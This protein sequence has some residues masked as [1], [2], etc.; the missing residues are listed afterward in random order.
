MCTQC[1][2]NKK[3]KCCVAT[4]EERQAAAARCDH[5]IKRGFKACNGQ[6]PCDVCI[7]HNTIG[8]CRPTVEANLGQSEDS[9]SQ[10]T[11]VIQPAGQ[12]TASGSA[13]STTKANTSRTQQKP[14]RP[15][16]L[17]AEPSSVSL[18]AMSGTKPSIAVRVSKKRKVAIQSTL[19]DG[20]DTQAMALDALLQESAQEHCSPSPQAS[21]DSVLGDDDS[22]HGR[23]GSNTLSR[24]SD[25]FSGHTSENSLTKQNSSTDATSATEEDEPPRKPTRPLHEQSP[26]SERRPRRSRGRVSYAEVPLDAFSDDELATRSA[27]DD[28]DA[29]DVYEEGVAAS[30]DSDEASAFGDSW[31]HRMSISEDEQDTEVEVQEVADDISTGDR[32]K[33]RQKPS[34]KKKAA[35]KAPRTGKGIDLS[36]PPMTTIEDIFEDMGARALQ[37]GLSN[38][39]KELEGHH[40]NVATMCSGTESPIL[41][42]DL[43]SKGFEKAGLPPLR[44]KHHFSA[45]IEATKQSY[46]ERNFSP[47]LIF[48]DV[49]EFIPDD[50]LTAITAYGAEAR[51]PSEIDVLIAG[52]VC[53][54]LSRL[55]SQQKTLDDDGESG[56]TFRAVYSLT[57]KTRPRIVLLENVKSESKVWD[58]IVSRWK[59]IDYEAGWLICDTKNYYLPQTRERMYMIAIDRRQYAEKATCIVDQWKELM[60]EL[61]RQCSSPYEAFLVHLPQTPQEYNAL[62]SESDWALCKLRYDHI[63]SEQRLGILRPITRWDE[64]GVVR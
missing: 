12:R 48:R 38:V 33:L 18:Q 4:I 21:P 62:I 15:T 64:N 8:R 16:K 17:A 27:S 43:L 3:S 10:T 60:R 53:K 13:S 25:R 44:I 45:E 1:I 61:R 24:T 7:K 42:L 49:R 30:T 26:V 41:A 2:R 52:F 39:L 50:S 56:D 5:C 6:N 37:M 31:N 14:V 47:P 59:E 55:N 54:D 58:T 20:D 29:S 9:T 63:R 40:I 19:D 36:L 46:I 32:P 11:H 22:D 51:L 28:S 23:E 34:T 57:K 35:Q